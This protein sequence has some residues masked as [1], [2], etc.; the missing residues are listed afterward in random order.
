MD[1]KTIS[2]DL[3]SIYFVSRSISIIFRDTC[4][5]CIMLKYLNKKKAIKKHSI[6]KSKSNTF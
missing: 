3:T 6:K 1:I 5:L 4:T 2:N